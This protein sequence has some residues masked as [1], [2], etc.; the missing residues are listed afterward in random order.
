MDRNS[1]IGFALLLILG[2]IYIFWNSSEQQKYQE[3]QM[4]DSLAKAELLAQQVNIEE[5]SNSSFD[6]ESDSSNLAETKTLKEEIFS[7]ENKDLALDFTNKGAFPVKANIKKYK[8]Y[9]KEELVL[10]EGDKNK[11]QILIPHDGK[12]IGSDALFFTP[13]LSKLPNG[14][15]QLR[16]TAKVNADKQV[17]LDYILPKEGYLLQANMRLIGFDQELAHGKSIPI[18]WSTELFQTEKDIESERRNMQ[19]HYKYHNGSHDYNAIERTSDKSLKKDVYWFSVRSQFFNSTIIADNKMENVSFKATKNYTADNGKDVITLNETEFSIPTSVS[20]DFSFP[21][22][23]FIGP[24]DY[25]LLKNQ[26]ID[27]LEELIQLGIGPFFFVKYISKWLLIPI[28][29]FLNANIVS[30]GLIIILLTLIIRIPLS[31]FTYKSHLS[32]AKMRVLK[33][34]LDQIKEKYGGDQQQMGMEQMKLYRTAGV[35]PLGGCLPMLIQ[36][37]FLLS[38]YYFFPASI[39][40]RQKSFLWADDLSTYDSILDFGFKIPLYGDHISLFTLFMA[41]TSLILALYNRNMTSAGAG[42]DNQMAQM[43]KYMPYIMPFM[44]LGWFNNFAAGLTFYYTL[45]NLISIAQQFVI[46]K[47][48]INEDKLLAQIEENKN[49]PAGTSKWQQRLEEMQ[50]MQAERAKQNR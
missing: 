8:T 14:S 4:A 35:N 42:A 39:H 18:H 29:D 23:W 32:T 36:M 31:F 38:M 41:A 45:S 26:G 24:N 34:E 10:F 44:F 47:F 30:I 2:G 11:M 1:L 7:L 28:F 9:T 40:L 3:Q 15:Q 43:M 17:I 22:Q 13:E 50:K 48:M 20:S 12:V 37:P 19:V 33:P 46:Q 21:F 5:S 25:K 27:D 49:K 6:S 16:F